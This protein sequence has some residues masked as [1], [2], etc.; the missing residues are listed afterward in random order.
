MCCCYI[1]AVLPQ[2]MRAVK[3]GFVA[4]LWQPKSWTMATV[5][6]S[7]VD[8]LS[9]IC[10]VERSMQNVLRGVLMTWHAL[11][12]FEHLP[13]VCVFL[14][15]LQNN[16]LSHLQNHLILSATRQCNGWTCR[17]RIFDRLGLRPNPSHASKDVSPYIKLI[18]Q[19][20]W[21]DRFASNGYIYRNEIHFHDLGVWTL[22]NSTA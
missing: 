22:S 6:P 19:N 1:A 12:V 20:W 14:A 5:F 16:A 17:L 10:L 18:A 11:M 21:P 7:G 9:T 4:V 13:H 2:Y 8:C 15:S 3:T